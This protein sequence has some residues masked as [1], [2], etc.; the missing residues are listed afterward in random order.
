[1]NKFLILLALFLGLN[2]ILTAQNRKRLPNP[3]NSA[4]Y[5]EYAPSITAD[6]KTLIYQTSQ[7]GIFVNA[8][9]KVPQIDADGKST[10]I[11][12]EFETHFF[13]IFEV[14]L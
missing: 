4:E 5:T 2:N 7:Y 10:K 8:T 6:G 12:D 14:K 3:I 13:G 1:M 11:L 9:K